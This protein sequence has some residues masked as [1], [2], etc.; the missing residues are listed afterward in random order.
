MKKNGKCKK[1]EKKGLYFELGSKFYKTTVYVFAYKFFIDR[2]WLKL[3]NNDTYVCAFL[4]KDIVCVFS[5]DDNGEKVYYDINK[6]IEEGN[7]C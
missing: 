4:I 7:R 5:Y 6:M 1:K 2:Y 3:C